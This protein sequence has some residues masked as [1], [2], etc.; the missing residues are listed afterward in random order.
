MVPP[1]VV[2]GFGREQ[3]ARAIGTPRKAASTSRRV[4]VDHER[5]GLRMG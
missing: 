3:P 1:K 5:E 2:P 4:S